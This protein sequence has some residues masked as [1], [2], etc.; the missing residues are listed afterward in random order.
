M[1]VPFLAN[2]IQIP[3]LDAWLASSQAASSALEEKARTGC[4]AAMRRPIVHSKAMPKRLITVLVAALALLVAGP[5]FAQ[6]PTAT[7][8]PGQPPANAS[9]A[10]KEIYRD[11]RADGK[12]DVCSHTRDA[13][14]KALDTIETQ[15][16]TDYPD[17]RE[18]VK[19]G[20][21]RHDKGRCPD[22]A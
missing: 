22:D 17:F 21:Q 19:A 13:L 3:S 16:D 9:S 8:A 20:I 15:F 7:A 11:Y 12:I 10:V 14:Q 5:A 1:P 2:W 4:S 18:A 6:D